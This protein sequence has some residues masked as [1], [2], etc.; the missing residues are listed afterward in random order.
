MRRIVLASASPRRQEL[1]TLIS[2]NVI[3]V[4]SG[5]EEIRPE[6]IEAGEVPRYFATLKAQSVASDFPDDVVVGCDTAVLLEG[7]ILSKPESQEDAYKKL[8]ALSGKTH[9]V[10]TGCAIISGG[11]EK[12]FSS[13]TE[14]EFYPL[15]DDEILKYIRTG[16]CMDKAGAYAIQ[17]KGALF[18]KAIKGDYF[19]VV[20]LPV[21]ELSRM[22]REFL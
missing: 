9:H 7:E 2:H 5:E 13:V 4:P 14:V 6:G 12:S 20:G 1:I 16:E 21:A 11:S 17:G 18:V 15:S 3:A 10:I 19:N 8:K 22:I